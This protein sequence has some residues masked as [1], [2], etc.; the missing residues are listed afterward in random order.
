MTTLCCVSVSQE[1]DKARKD[2]ERIIAELRT[3]SEADREAHALEMEI[4]K[5]GDGKSKRM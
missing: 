4:L 3:K 5:V 2:R 1:L